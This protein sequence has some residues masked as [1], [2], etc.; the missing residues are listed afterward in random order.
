MLSQ[1]ERRPSNCSTFEPY[2]NGSGWSDLQL[3]LMSDRNPHCSK[4]AR[5][6]P[7]AKYDPAVRERKILLENQLAGNLQAL[8]PFIFKEE[9]DELGGELSDDW[10]KFQKDCS[11]RNKEKCNKAYRQVS[12]TLRK[13]LGWEEELGGLKVFAAHPL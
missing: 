5:S 9:Y 6:R 4:R 12:Q 11:I 13:A 3:S 2:K 1:V 10:K 8:L 7:D